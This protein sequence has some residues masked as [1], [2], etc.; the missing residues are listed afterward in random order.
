MS[1]E[2]LVREWVRPARMRGTLDDIGIGLPAAIVAAAL[3]WRFGVTRAGFAVFA[4]GLTAL[5]ALAWVRSRRFGRGWL[6]AALN[7]AYGDLED[8]ADLLFFEPAALGPLQLLQRGRVTARLAD[9]RFVLRPTWSMRWLLATWAFGA[10]TVAAILLWPATPRPRLA[11]SA[12]GLASA[13]GIPRLVGQR[14]RVVPPDYTGLPA[15]DLDTLDTPAPQGSRLAW[16]LAFAPAPT[17]AALAFM[18]GRRIPLLRARDTWTARASLDRSALYRVMPVGARQVGPL[19]RLDAVVDQPP[20]ATVLGP[21]HTLTVATPG[22][23]RWALLYEAQDDYGV[24]PVASLR[25]TTASGEGEQ[26]TFR[27]RTLALR[28]SGPPRRRR[29]ATTLDLAALGFTGPGDLVAELTVADNRNPAPQVARAP[30]LILRRLPPRQAQATGLD[31]AV[32]TALPAY[33]RSQRQVIIDAEALLR[34]RRALP[35]DRFATKS[36]A[37]GG[38]QHALRMHYGEFLGQ[39]TEGLAPALPTADATPTSPV[40]GRQEDVLAQFAQEKENPEAAT[41]FDPATKARLSAAVDQMWQSELALNQ[42]DPA[43][44][45]PYANRALVLIK[46]VQQATRVFVARVGTPDLP[47][48]DEGRRLTGKRDDIGSDGLAMAPV[49]GDSGAAAR[50]WAAASDAAGPADLAEVSR[51]IRSGGARGGDPLAL[52]AALDAAMRAPTCKSC[53]ERLRAQLWQALQ[54]PTP[55]ITRHADGGQ[56]GGRYLDALRSRR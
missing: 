16:T 20:T 9:D 18:D 46:L 48:I 27:E 21:A 34:Q 30:S 3:T 36:Q 51:W 54:R 14:L 32:R 50:A 29:F 7:A 4:V 47:P 2:A 31:G 19:H 5:V 38:D 1:G 24:A 26:V 33:L 17:S 13:S 12:E 44:A 35:V 6:I 23:A 15:R 25:L 42:G 8:S 10:M 37:I 28:A 49:E 40:L 22:Q 11:P 55:G 52:A 45:L 43:R 41:L 56:A 53:R 39:E